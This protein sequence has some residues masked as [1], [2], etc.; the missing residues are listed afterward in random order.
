MQEGAVVA[1]PVSVTTT[2]L[3]LLSSMFAKSI[4]EKQI[5]QIQMNR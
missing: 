2:S 4:S 3:L 1:G 5:V